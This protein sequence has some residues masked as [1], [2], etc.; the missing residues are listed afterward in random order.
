MNDRHRGRALGAEHMN[1]THDIVP[2]LGFLFR[3][4]VKVDVVQMLFHL[5]DLFLR[6]VESELPFGFR[7][8]DPE[9]SPGGVLALRGPVVTHFRAGV[10]IGQR[11]LIGAFVAVHESFSSGF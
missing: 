1:M 4:G 6:D 7:K 5:V 8:C 10:T 9:S 2:K 11:T 3:H